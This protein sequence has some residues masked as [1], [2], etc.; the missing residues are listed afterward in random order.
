MCFLNLEEGFFVFVFFVL[1]VCII[2]GPIGTYIE[3]F[4]LLDNNLLMNCIIVHMCF[5]C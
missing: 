4:L 1:F 2:V 5:G 3:F